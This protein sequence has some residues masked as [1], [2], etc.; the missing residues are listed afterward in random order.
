[1][2]TQPFIAT[3]TYE[4]SP[5]VLTDRKLRRVVEVAKERLERVKVDQEI[6]ERYK[7]RFL[8]EKE[9]RVDSLESVLGLDNSI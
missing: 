6:H 1:M 3:K 7:V 4:E 5:F 9:L 8:D 2:A